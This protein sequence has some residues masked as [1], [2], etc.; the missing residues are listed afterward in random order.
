MRLCLGLYDDYNRHPM[1]EQRLYDLEI[2]VSYLT[3]HMQDL[4]LKLADYKY[5]LGY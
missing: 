1:F 2:G 5:F 4:L 3:E